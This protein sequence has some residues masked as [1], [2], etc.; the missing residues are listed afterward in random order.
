MKR[1]N[2]RSFVLAVV[3]LV[4][5]VDVATGLM[6]LL[7]ESPW[8]LVGHAEAYS[9]LPN[10]VTLDTSLVRYLKGV[11]FRMGAYAFHV[12]VLAAFWAW[13]ARHN[14][15]MLSSLLL[16]YS[17]NAVLILFADYT[18]LAGTG[19]FQLKLGLGALWIL[20]IVAHFRARGKP[21]KGE[22]PGEGGDVAAQ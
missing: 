9:E 15:A 13:I 22:E 16:V 1:I 8:L 19:Y 3:F 17:L 4:A 2:P 10:T 20:A 21:G 5:T 6:W 7:S 11:Y 18:F 12:G 14:W